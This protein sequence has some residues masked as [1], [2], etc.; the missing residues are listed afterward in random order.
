MNKKVIFPVMLV[1]LLALS[2]AFVG[3]DNGSTSNYPPP[4]HGFEYSVGIGTLTI[5]GA[6]L[7]SEPQDGDSFTLSYDGSTLT[8]TIEVAGSSVTFK[9]Q[10]GTTAFT[11]TDVSNPVINATISFDDGSSKAVN[12]TLNSDKYSMHGSGLTQEEWNTFG[13]GSIDPS[14]LIDESYNDTVVAQYFIALAAD[15]VGRHAYSRSEA[16]IRALLADGGISAGDITAIISKL[17][18]QGW[19]LYGRDAVVNPLEDDYEIIGI[20]TE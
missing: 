2:L 16:Q 20:I 8:G 15:A 18:T 4:T 10:S 12:E 5:T 19:V 9:N 1:G 13:L 6:G 3:C 17:K 7:A 11:I 14:D